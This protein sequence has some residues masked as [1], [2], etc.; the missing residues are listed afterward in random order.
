[1]S[2]IPKAHFVL[3]FEE[4]II[5]FYEVDL[6]FVVESSVLLLAP[7]AAAA[8]ATTGLSFFSFLLLVGEK[9]KVRVGGC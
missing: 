1:M 6:G 9:C 7:A 8:D 3:G 4:V 5:C 2:K